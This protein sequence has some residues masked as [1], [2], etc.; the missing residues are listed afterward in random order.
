VPRTSHA[1]PVE[2]PA[3]AARVI[4]DFLAA[5]LPAATLMPVRR[6]PAGG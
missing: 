6:T 5:E 2:R 1:L 3:E 4:L